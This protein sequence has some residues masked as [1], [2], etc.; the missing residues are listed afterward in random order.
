MAAGPVAVVGGG[1]V[2]LVLFVVVILGGASQDDAANSPCGTPGA[3]ISVDAA[4]LPTQQVGAY[5]PAQ[6]ANAVAIINAGKAMGLSAR[7]QT[8]GIMTAIG[9][10]SLTVVDHGDIA[11]PDSRGLFQQ[12]ANGAWGTL[13]D[14][15]NPAISATSFFK[16]LAGVAGR[17]VMTPTAVA[18]AVQRNADP[19][20]YAKFWDVAVAI[21]TQLAGATVT[22]IST[23]T[24]QMACTNN[25][26]ITSAVTATGWVRPNNGPLYSKFG[27]RSNPGQISHG[28]Y[29]LH[30]GIDLAGACDSPILAAAD[31]IVVDISYSASGGHTI[32]VDNGGG[33]TTYYRHMFAAQV[34]AT[35]GQQVKA[36]AQIG[37]VGRDGNATGCHLHFEV[38]QVDAQGH[39]QPIDPEPFL[40]TRGVS[41]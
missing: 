11:G 25:S 15:M 20:H 10:S 39:D 30:A 36:G 40:A 23:G 18:H 4:S 19:F 28:Q 35:I 24:G 34:M 17:D 6:L 16:A 12:R 38:H 5:G 31:G 1:T 27:M 7:D 37:R 32:V 8:I 33:T 14:R 3:G 9:E 22:G 21:V 13:A 2:A 41:V 29:R 26:P